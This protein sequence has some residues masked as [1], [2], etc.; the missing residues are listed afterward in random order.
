[1]DTR[2]ATSIIV[3]ARSAGRRTFTGAVCGY[4]DG[5]TSES[6]WCKCYSNRRC[7]CLVSGVALTDSLLFFRFFATECSLIVKR[8]PRLLISEGRNG[9]DART[10][11]QNW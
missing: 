7:H 8:Q 5:T 11:E 4:L 1:M 9:E 2:V 6:G 10:S 3:R